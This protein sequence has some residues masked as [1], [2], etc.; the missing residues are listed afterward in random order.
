MQKYF[1][2]LVLFY[3]LCSGLFYTQCSPV[4]LSGRGGEIRGLDDDQ[5]TGSNRGGGG[6]RGNN[7]DDD[8]DD[9]YDD[10]DDDRPRRGCL[11]NEDDCESVRDD[12]DDDEDPKSVSETYSELKDKYGKGYGKLD[13]NPNRVMDFLAG[14]SPNYEITKGRIYVDLDRVQSERY[15]RGR[16]AVALEDQLSS[17]EHKVRVIRFDSGSKNDSKYNIWA[18]FG[19]KLGFHGFFADTKGY[20]ALILV[21][22]EGS[23]PLANTDGHRK[24]VR[25]SEG[26]LWFMNFKTH[27]GNNHNKCYE[28]GEYIG[29]RKIPP[30]P[31]KK[32]WFIKDGPFDCRAW[33]KGRSKDVDPLKALEPTSAS[34]YQKLADFSKLNIEEAFNT[35]ED[36]DEIFITR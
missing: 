8:D 3:L 18:R 5:S 27:T 32:C 11:Y 16:I 17:R 4:K 30:L 29:R 20:G 13:V 31:P 2:L 6:R 9:D 33:R 28:G 14:Y 10:D 7:N 34:C 1:C 24:R 35:E 26:S 36:D 25:F 12:D 21:L 19:N 15:Y 22:E 23:D